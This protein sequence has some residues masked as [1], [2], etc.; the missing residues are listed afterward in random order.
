MTEGVGFNYKVPSADKVP[1][2]Y[3]DAMLE[4]SDFFQNIAKELGEDEFIR[5]QSIQQL[6]EWIAKHPH[7]KRCRTDAP[8][9]L[10]FLRAKKYSFINA[11]KTLE[12]FLTARTKHR[13][14]FNNFD[15]DDPAL[16]DLVDTSYLF[17]LP[18][19]DSKGRVVFF[20]C[21]SKF[22]PA[23]HTIISP[24]QL[25]HMMGEIYYETQEISCA[26]CVWIFDMEKTD[27]RV[28]GMITVQD[29]RTLTDLVNTAAA[30]R[31]KELHFINTPAVFRTIANLILQ[32]MSE[33]IRSRVFCHPS[34]EDLHSKMDK[35]LLPKEFGGELPMAELT[36]NYKKLCR[37]MRPRLLA[38][39]DMEIE[40]VDNPNDIWTNYSGRLEDGAIGSFRKLQ[41]D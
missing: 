31:I 21:S 23:K 12:S 33:K 8:F 18:R 26:G 6:R 20:I 9:L 35:S 14:W 32:L 27:K 19:L 28:L 16:A 3:D 29:I 17:P 1:E 13:Q 24:I 5:E 34:L 40:L 37:K 25:I 36:A 11:A 7:I 30:A 22:N 39:N 10:R 2:I 15:I 41:V 38:M 4:M